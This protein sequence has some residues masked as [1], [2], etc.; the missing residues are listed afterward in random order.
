MN[1]EDQRL[2]NWTKITQLLFEAVEFRPQSDSIENCQS[3][4]PKS[5]DCRKTVEKKKI[6]ECIPKI[7]WIWKQVLNW[8]N[9]QQNG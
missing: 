7:H 9:Y 3:Y 1:S 2:R 8:V 5:E 6:S 4:L